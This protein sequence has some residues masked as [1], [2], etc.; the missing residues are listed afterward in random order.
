MN[1]D[2]L[3]TDDIRVEYCDG[4]RRDIQRVLDACREE[5]RP[6]VVI[7]EQGT[8]SQDRLATIWIR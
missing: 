3:H 2:I 8:K 6:Y 1:F 5:R 7:K 4:T